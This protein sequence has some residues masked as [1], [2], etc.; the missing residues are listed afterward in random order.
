MIEIRSLDGPA[1]FES[2]KWIL[3]MFFILR[4]RKIVIR[5]ETFLFLNSLKNPFW[6]KSKREQILEDFSW[7]E[8][9]RTREERN[10]RVRI[11][12]HIHPVI[13]WVNIWPEKFSNPYLCIIARSGSK[14]SPLIAVLSFHSFRFSTFFLSIL[15]HWFLFLLFFT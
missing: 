15:F 13:G 3:Q 11:Q 9:E 5:W 12:K 2:G 8:G 1:F 7:D 4:G 14:F 6:L 10:K